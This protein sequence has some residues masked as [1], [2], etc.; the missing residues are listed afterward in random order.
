MPGMNIHSDV[1][2]TSALNFT[3]VESAKWKSAK[4]GLNF[5]PFEVL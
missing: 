4:F 5:R 2:L 3:E 1:S